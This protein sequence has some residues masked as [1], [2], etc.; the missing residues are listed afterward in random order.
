MATNKTLRYDDDSITPAPLLSCLTPTTNLLANGKRVQFQAR[1]Y[2]I[3]EVLLVG[4]QTWYSFHQT[5]HQPSI[6]LA[7]ETS[8]VMK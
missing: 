3:V 8:I 1:V 6:L 7:C 4:R 5:N 2:M